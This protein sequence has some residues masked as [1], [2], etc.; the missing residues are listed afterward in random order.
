VLMS[1]NLHDAMLAVTAARRSFAI[2]VMISDAGGEAID[3]ET[4]P[5]RVFWLRPERNILVHA[6]HF[7]SP[8]ALAAVNDLSL[9]V[10]PDSLFRERRVREYLDLRHGRISLE[11][12]QEAFADRYGSPY[13]VCR[14][15]DGSAEAV[16][17]VAT[18]LM[19]VTARSITIA[20]TPYK[21]HA[22]FETWSV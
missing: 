10:T 11:S 7:A 8:G 3:F 9:S 6:N 17:T 15:D 19:D 16:V 12:M 4:T 13:G 21:G 22:T 1:E 20:R 14:E 5:E 2:N 18:V